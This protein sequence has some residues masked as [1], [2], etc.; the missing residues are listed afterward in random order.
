MFVKG[1]QSTHIVRLRLSRCVIHLLLG[2]SIRHL[3]LSHHDA[4][5]LLLLLLLRVIRSLL[6]LLRL[7]IHRLLLTGVINMK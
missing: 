6:L 2:L 4:L 3:R 5:L 7:I 1:E